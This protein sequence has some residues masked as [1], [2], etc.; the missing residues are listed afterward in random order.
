MLQITNDSNK[1]NALA[2]YTTSYMF[3]STMP[4]AMDVLSESN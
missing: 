1:L 3:L 2:I 4:V